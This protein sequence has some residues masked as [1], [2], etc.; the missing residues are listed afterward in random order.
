MCYHA[1]SLAT[2]L[3]YNVKIIG[4]L[5]TVPH[6]MINNNQH[7]S[8]VPLPSPPDRFSRL[9]EFAQLPLKFIWSFIVLS[10]ALLF[11]FISTYISMAF[12]FQFLRFYLVLF[13]YLKIGFGV[14][15][16]LLQNPPALPTMI[17]CL[18]VARLK[19][20]KFVIDWHNYMWS[21]LRDKSGLFLILVQRYFLW[22][23]FVYFYQSIC[24]CLSQNFK[25]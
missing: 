21:V 11:R 25:Y 12:F 16:V 7:I 8:Y 9:P 15:L 22:S 24:S 1:Y 14:K 3:Q 5:D 23:L 6:R 18:M 2:R 10:W 19:N 17:V 4:Y 20:A 13:I